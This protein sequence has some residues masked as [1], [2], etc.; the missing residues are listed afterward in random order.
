MKRTRY[1]KIQYDID[2]KASKVLALLSCKIYK[3]E[4]LGGKEILPFLSK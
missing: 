2:T 3:Y 1:G 4:Y